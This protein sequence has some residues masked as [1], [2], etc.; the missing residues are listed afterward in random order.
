MSALSPDPWRYCV[1][2]MMDCTDRHARYLLRLISRRARLYT[3]MVTA[4]ALLHG[5]AGRLLAHAA[6]EHPLALQL[7]GSDP[8]Q[9]AAAARLGEAHGYQEINLNAGCPSDRVSAGRFGACLMLEPARVADCVAAMRAAV[10][11]PVTVKCRIGVDERDRYA[12]LLAFVD[13]VAGAGCETFIV[14]ARKAWLSGLSPK[15]NRDIPPLRHHEVHRLKR[16]RPALRIVINGGLADVDAARAQLAQVDGVMLGRAAYHDCW[17]LAPVD[18][19][20]FGGAGPVPQRPVVLEAYCQYMERQRAA[21][22]PL[23]PM[24]RHLLG[25]YQGVPGARAWRRHLSTH[26]HRRDA[27]VDVVREAARRVSPAAHAA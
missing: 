21:G 18:T 19:T 8:A 2:P 10:Q 6:A 15:Q 12:D 25:F 16:E 17:S 7:G 13:E 24:A 14:H 5:D 11:V 23:A 9:L 22:V 4:A 26:M 20:L 1:A 3:E 27:E